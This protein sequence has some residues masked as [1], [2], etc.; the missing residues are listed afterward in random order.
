MQSNDSGKGKGYIHKVLV[1]V[2][3]LVLVFVFAIIL[4][5]RRY[6]VV[7]EEIGRTTS[8]HSAVDAV[9]IRTDYG[10]TSSF[11]YNIYVVPVNAKP[12]KGHEIFSADRLDGLEVVWRE[13]KLLEIRYDEARIFHFSNFA[14]TGS[15]VV[16]IRLVPR[17]T[18]SRKEF[19]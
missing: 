10:A 17:E 14:R 8:P 11:L 5:V 16:E 9:T 19:K 7:H 1:S 4:L 2:V 6:M 12:E 13:P 18:P 3:L 15:Y